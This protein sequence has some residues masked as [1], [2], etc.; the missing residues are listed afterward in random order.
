VT[1]RD[2]ELFALQRTLYES[3]NPTRRWLHRSRRDWIVAALQ[4]H[5]AGAH[6]VLEV[7]PG[8]GV[9]LPT[10]AET[11]DKVLA[12][13]IEDAYLARLSPITDEHPNVSL[14]RDDITRSNL[15]TRSFDLI[16]CTEV[17]EHIADSRAALREMG[18]LLRPN[19]VLILSTPQRYSTLEICGRVAFWPGIVEF[20]RWVYKEPI[21]ETGHINLMTRRELAAQ[22]GA[23]G[24]TV[25]ESRLAG[26]YIP[27]LAEAM[28][29]RALRIEKALET[30]LRTR[31][32]LSWLLWTQ[33]VIATR[34]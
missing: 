29:H 28:G 5:G 4:R 31:P 15:E 21:L 10:L 17:I 26:V 34:D 7:G 20:V 16:L 32:M 24:F 2:E 30:R 8:S 11:A 13:D 23:T 14:V 12:S 18:R 19:G 25:R 3:N 33:F 9:Y 27:V 6:R 1:D 22:L